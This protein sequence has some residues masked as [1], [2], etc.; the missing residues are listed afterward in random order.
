MYV[1]A[2]EG[3]NWHEFIGWGGVQLSFVSCFF[4]RGAVSLAWGVTR[5]I[6]LLVVGCYSCRVLPYVGI[7][8]MTIRFYWSKLKTR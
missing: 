7:R 2:R 6:L 4:G 5:M 3:M 8:K 1:C